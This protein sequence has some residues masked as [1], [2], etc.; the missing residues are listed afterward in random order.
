MMGMDASTLTRNLRVLTDS[1]WVLSGP[2]P[3]ARSRTIALTAA[4]RDKLGQAKACWKRAQL[5]LN[6][7]LGDEQVVALHA[8]LDL[9][10]AALAQQ[11][12][13]DE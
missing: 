7:L 6:A 3:D 4:G 1:G 13:V 11:Q 2:G 8:L 5:G 9:S 12:G 10:L